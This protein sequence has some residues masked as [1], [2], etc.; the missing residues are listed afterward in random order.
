MRLIKSYFPLI[1]LLI[2]LICSIECRE[3]NANGRRREKSSSKTSG[4]LVSHVP[5]L[6]EKDVDMKIGC[7]CTRDHSKQRIKEVD[8]LILHKELSQSDLSW[9]A[10]TSHNNINQISLTVTRNGYMGYLPVSLFQNQ[11]ELTSVNIRFGNIREIPA[12]AFG[13][14]TKLQNISLE[15]NEIEIIND[16]AFANLADLRILNLDDN[17]IVSIGSKAF[18]N[19]TLLVEF[20]AS[21]NN[22]TSLPDDVFVDLMNLHTM[23]LSENYLNAL[24]KD[25]FKGM[26]KL[27]ILDLSFNNLKLL[28]PVFTELW[29]L[30]ELYLDNNQLEVGSID[31]FLNFD[32]IYN[33]KKVFFHN[34]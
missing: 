20:S 32:L 7:H 3:R 16:R 28:E 31:F 30:Q 13:E 14:Q 15:K 18:V 12:R 21:K 8:C 34:C 17:Q 19:L 33:T 23:R 2:S 5:N 10:F 24:T 1:F 25:V 6:C 29:S 22:L 26:G 11:R 9:R 4:T 27:H